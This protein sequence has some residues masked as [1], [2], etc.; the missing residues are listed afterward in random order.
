[1]CFDYVVSH[2]KLYYKEKLPRQKIQ[3]EFFG[4]KIPLRHWPPTS[5]YIVPLIVNKFSLSYSSK[6]QDILKEL[7]LISVLYLIFNAA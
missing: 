2:G 4:K 1:M 6:N 3:A 7:Q 5:I